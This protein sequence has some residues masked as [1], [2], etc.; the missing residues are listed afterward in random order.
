MLT[1]L[2]KTP[3]TT[4]TTTVATVTHGAATAPPVELSLLSAMLVPT[5]SQIQ[6]FTD[7]FQKL[8]HENQPF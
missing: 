3:K 5:Q 4:S 6:C 7:M 1:Y 2:Y 8:Q